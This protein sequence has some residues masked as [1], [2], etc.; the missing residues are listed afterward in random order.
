MTRHGVD[1]L[2]GGADATVHQVHRRVVPGDV[3]VHRV[4]GEGRVEVVQH[5]ER[6][7]VERIGGD[8]VAERRAGVRGRRR[9]AVGTPGEGVGRGALAGP[10][11][12]HAGE[13]HRP[14]PVAGGGRRAGAVGGGAHLI[15]GEVD[16]RVAAGGDGRERPD[17]IVEGDAEGVEGERAGRRREAVVH[18]EGDVVTGG[19]H[20]RRAGHHHG[21]GLGGRETP[22]RHGA[23]TGHRHGA[24]LGPQLTAGGAAVGRHRLDRGLV[25]RCDHLVLAESIGDGGTAGGQHERGDDGGDP[26]E[27]RAADE[28]AR[29]E[30]VE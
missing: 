28:H 26:H 12:E 6:L 25:G 10:H 13:A 23:D 11:H 27:G 4:G 9:V 20:D 17:P 3:G 24:G 18:R 15:G 30:S 7:V 1:H 8:V 2:G 22:H 5:D 14:L 16:R 21:S 19:R 29:R